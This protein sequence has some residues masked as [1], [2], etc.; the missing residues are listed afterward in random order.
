MYCPH[1]YRLFTYHYGSQVSL[2]KLHYIEIM[3]SWILS[4]VR[5]NEKQARSNWEICLLMVTVAREDFASMVW[6]LMPNKLSTIIALN[7]WLAFRDAQKYVLHLLSSCPISLIFTILQLSN[8]LENLN[9]ITPW[10]L[11]DDI[12]DQIR[13]NRLIALCSI[14][15]LTSLGIWR[16]IAKW[17][18][19]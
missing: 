8:Y 3:V 4:S 6:A 16:K 11:S 15:K 18:T 14:G 17:G 12:V 5:S 1:L 13:L 10:I 19:R 2:L 9:V 7:L